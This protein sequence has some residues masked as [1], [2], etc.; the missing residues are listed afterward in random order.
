MWMT[1]DG[2]VME[3]RKHER[4]GGKK[5]DDEDDRETTSVRRTSV[6]VCGVCKNERERGMEL[7][8]KTVM[9]LMV[10]KVV[11]GGGK[12]GRRAKDK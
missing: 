3:H 4:G 10:M 11:E 8:M 7:A 1:A 5:R 6:S 9:M 12:K 2:R